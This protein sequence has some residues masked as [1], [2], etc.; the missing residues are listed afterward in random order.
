[1]K[2]LSTIKYLAAVVFV[3]LVLTG[4]SSNIDVNL[5]N[6]VKVKYEAVPVL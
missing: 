6:Y 3:A 4:C 1:M 5:N 2:V